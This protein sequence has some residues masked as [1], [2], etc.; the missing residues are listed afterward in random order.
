MF[1]LPLDRKINDH[2]PYATFGLVGLNTLCFFVS[3]W[4]VRDLDGFEDLWVRFGFVPSSP[5][6]SA[7]ITHLFIHA[8]W[9]HLAGNMV[10]LVCM[11][12]NCE[13]KLG[14]PLY[15]ALYFVSGLGA[16][17]LFTVFNWTSDLPLG[18]ASGA[19]AGVAGMYLALFARREVD[20]LWWALVAAGTFTI[21]AWIAPILW[22]GTEVA[23]AVLLNDRHSV[24]NWAHVGGFLVGSGSVAMLVHLFGFRGRP[25]PMLPKILMPGPEINI[26]PL[27]PTT[28]VA[29]EEGSVSLTDDLGGVHRLPFAAFYLLSAGAVRTP[30]GPRMI[31]DL[32]ATAPW[33]V[34]RLTEGDLALLARELRNRLPHTSAAPDFA[35]LAEQGAIS[36]EPFSDLLAYDAFNQG[37]LRAQ[38]GLRM[39]LAV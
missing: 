12:M 25:E 16:L 34:F 9:I 2:H 14:S 36:G 19:V 4:S 22:A 38:V 18:G 7:A 15:L 5:S 27:R 33:T 23:Q 21:P 10:F 30:Q 8:N 3:L 20:V 24:A 29:F 11:G 13:R 28:R 6:A 39:D 31:V 32:F 35:L 37:L 17:L 1:L 26:P